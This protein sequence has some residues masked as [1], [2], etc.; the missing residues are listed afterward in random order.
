MS[1]KVKDIDIKKR[2]N[3]SFNDIINIKNFDEDKIKIDEKSYKGI[4]VDYIQNTSLTKNSD[5]YVQKYLKIKLN[6]DDESPLNKTIK[7]PSMIIVVRAAF[8][9][10]NKHYSQFF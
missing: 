1:N 3:Y 9:E 10:N 6:S 5:D 4:L 2:T 8:H 7:I